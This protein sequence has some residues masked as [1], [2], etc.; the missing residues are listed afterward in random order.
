M[1]E[2]P[3]KFENRA[4][5][6]GRVNSI[7]ITKI[8]KFTVIYFD[9]IFKLTA[10]AQSIYREIYDVGYQVKCTIL[11]INS[12]TCMQQLRAAVACS[13]CSRRVA[14]PLH[15]AH[16]AVN[17]TDEGCLHCGKA[18]RKCFSRWEGA[19]CR[20][21]RGKVQ[22]AE[23]RWEGATCWDVGGKVLP[24]G[25]AICWDAGGKMQP[26]GC[27][28]EG[29]TCWDFWGNELHVRMSV[30]RYNPLDVGGKVQ[31]AGMSVGRCYLLGC[32]WEGATCWNL[33]GN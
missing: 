12:C 30:G 17:R 29:T 1:V 7:L 2:F 9:D 31:R 10:R 6:I 5:K 33:H 28:W 14:W 27:R 11:W 8:Y 22:P 3:R 25:I 24:I 15:K 18:K 26:P 20:D 19:T 21:V 32:R 16:V 13:S 23:C 4:V